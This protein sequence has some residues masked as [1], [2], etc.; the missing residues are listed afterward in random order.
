MALFFDSDWF[1][2]QL[3]KAG[4]TRADA[5]QALGLNDMQLAELW[6]DQ[7]ELRAQDVRMLAALLAVTPGEVATRAGISTPAPSPDGR[8]LETRVTRVEV[9]L[10]AIRS[11]L[12]NLKEKLA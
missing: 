6:K 1:D 8:D 4:L 3:A 10:A 9:E 12:N 2:A 5:A 7:R 11:E